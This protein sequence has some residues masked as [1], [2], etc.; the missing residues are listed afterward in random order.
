MKIIAQDPAQTSQRVRVGMIGLAA[1]LLIIGLAAAIFSTASRERPFVVAGGA[2]PGVVANMAAGNNA[3]PVDAPTSEPLAELGIT[4]ST[5]TDA[6][7]DV[8]SSA[9][10]HPKP[11]Q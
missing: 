9:A 3:L 10:K 1:I 7:N 8:Q 2:H 4:P 6:G 11:I 5:A